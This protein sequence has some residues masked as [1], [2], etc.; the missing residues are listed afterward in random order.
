[1]S[2]RGNFDKFV[3]GNSLVEPIIRFVEPSQTDP[4]LYRL[5]S[6]ALLT[7]DKIA[8]PK[9]L[10][11]LSMYELKLLTILGYG[12]DVSTCVRCGKP[13]NIKKGYLD[14]NHGFPVCEGCKHGS[15]IPVM[16]GTFRFI[17]WA[18]DSSMNEAAKVTMEKPTL[19][20]IRSVIEG[21]FLLIFHNKLKSWQ[22]LDG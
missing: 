7:L 21:L 22:Q 1:V 4:S 17:T 13:M 11:L 3:I 16:E 14:Q 12:P 2:I 20:N 19:V 8:T 10:F 15:A 9:A 5:L 6:E 18:Q